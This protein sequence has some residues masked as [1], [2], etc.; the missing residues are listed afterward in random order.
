MSESLRCYRLQPTR[1]L[2]PWDSP[3]KNIEV[4]CH[5][6]FQ[7][8]FQ[9]Q[10]SNRHIF[11]SCIAFPDTLG[12]PEYL[13]CRTTGKEYLCRLSFQGGTR[14][15][16]HICH[17]KKHKRCSWISGSGRFLGI[18]HGNMLQY[19]CLENHMDRGAWWAIFHR[20][21]KNQI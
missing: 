16:E 15:K 10:G 1:L 21:A 4:G 8:I 20:V 6:L 14:S 12:G 13:Q 2:C 11:I 7:R 9:T 17:C 3:G 18:G 5:A 19:S